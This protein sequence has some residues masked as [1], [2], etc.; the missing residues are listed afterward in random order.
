MSDKHI[1]ENSNL[2]NNIIIIPGDTILADRGFDIQAS[3]GL[4]CATV[5]IPAFTRGEKQLEG[6]DIEQTRTIANVYIYNNIRKKYNMMGTTQPIDYLISKDKAQNSP[7]LL[8]MI[9]TVCC[10]LTNLCN[11][12]IP[13]D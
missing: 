7:T 5:T 10:A 13:F 11:S 9:V 8:D 6:I 4:Y 2:L 1:T 3:L 12:V